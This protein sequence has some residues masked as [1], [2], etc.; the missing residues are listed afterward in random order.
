[1]GENLPIVGK[2]ADLRVY[3]LLLM[4][5][6]GASGRKEWCEWTQEEIAEYL[7]L[8]PNTVASSL[9]RMVDV[10]GIVKRQR[11][12]RRDKH[13]LIYG[14]T[15]RSRMRVLA[16]KHRPR[17]L[18]RSASLESRVVEQAALRSVPAKETTV[19]TTGAIDAPPLV[20]LCPAG[21][22]C[23]RASEWAKG[24]T[25]GEAQK[26]VSVDSAQVRTSTPQMELD[27]PLVLLPTPDA[28]PIPLGTV[29]RQVRYRAGEGDPE[30]AATVRGDVLELRPVWGAPSDLDELRVALNSLLR[31]RL[32]PVSDDGL[33]RIAQALGDTPLELLVAKINS[34]PSMFTSRQRS[35]G[36]VETLAQEV[37]RAWLAEQGAQR[38]VTG[39]QRADQVAREIEAA[40]RSLA[41]ASEPELVAMYKAQIA[42]LRVQRKE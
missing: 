30:I 17:T 41:D 27:N 21:E 35:W 14:D 1:V 29:I 15:V 23:P 5:T 32:G 3:H 38:R 10:F 40:E 7:D 8:T 20:D 6:V 36:G 12:G 18:T 28:R 31:Q 37:R 2:P 34:R 19:I 22:R 16:Q 4:T 33:R 13:A 39:K 26:I 42:E 9:K 24:R 11:Y 25:N